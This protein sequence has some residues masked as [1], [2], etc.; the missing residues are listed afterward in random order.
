MIR[1]FKILM[2]ISYIVI[3]INTHGQN[4]N[5]NFP[6]STW[7]KLDSL[8][9]VGY[10]SKKIAEVNKYIINKMNTTGLVVVVDG[11][12]IFEYGDIEELSYIAS[13]RKSLLSMMYGKYVKNGI[14]DLDLTLEELDVNDVNGLLPIER[15]ATIRDLITARSGIY[16][17]RSNGGDDTKYAPERGSVKPGSYFLYNNWDFNAAGEIFEKLT[18]KDI[19][20]TFELDVAIPIQMQDFKIEKQ[21]KSGDSTKSNYL[22]YH[23]WISTRD[24]ARIGLLMLNNGNWDGVQV[25]PDEWVKLSTSTITPTSQFNPAFKREWKLAYGYLWWI[26]NDDNKIFEGAYYASGAYGQYLLIIPKLNMVISHKTKYAYKRRTDFPLFRE[27][28]YKII[29]S[30]LE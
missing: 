20:K 9:E 17:P 6:D 3:C 21:K 12:I 7:T 26:W 16:H 1:L 19:Y 23:F 10:D 15:Q 13:C 5:L 11:K 22:A 25:I 27:L 24:M 14:I 28:V 8:E 2:S 30:K 4:N 29:D 18:N